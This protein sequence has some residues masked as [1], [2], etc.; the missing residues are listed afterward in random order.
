METP[1]ESIRAT[2]LQMAADVADSEW[3]QGGV[4]WDPSV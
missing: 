1:V 2:R 3:G 4:T